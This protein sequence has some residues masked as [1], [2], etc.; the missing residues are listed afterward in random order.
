MQEGEKQVATRFLVG[1]RIVRRIVC[2]IVPIVPRT[3]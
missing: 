3:P 2:R 1:C